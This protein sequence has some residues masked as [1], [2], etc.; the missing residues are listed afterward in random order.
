METV[1]LGGAVG[2]TVRVHEVL[3]TVLRHD[4]VSFSLAHN[5][6]SG[7]PTPSLADLAVTRRLRSAA[8]AVGLRLLDHVVVAGTS[9]HSTG[10]LDR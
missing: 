4:G 1:A 3:A 6:P 9:W 5:H 8:D 10:A 7:D 2:A